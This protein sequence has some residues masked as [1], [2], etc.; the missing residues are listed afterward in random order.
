MCPRL[1]KREKEKRGGASFVHC[2]HLCVYVYVCSGRLW[3]GGGVGGI[4]GVRV[5]LGST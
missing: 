1:R 2:M 3:V 4:D 5:R